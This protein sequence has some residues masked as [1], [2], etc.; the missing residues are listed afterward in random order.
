MV[1]PQLD[2]T[3]HFK[4]LVY[5]PLAAGLA[6]NLPKDLDINHGLA[7]VVNLEPVSDTGRAKG[8]QQWSGIPN[9]FW[10]CKIKWHN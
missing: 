3:T 1:R 4:K 9:C 2:D 8:S 7:G 10:V 5:H 6:G